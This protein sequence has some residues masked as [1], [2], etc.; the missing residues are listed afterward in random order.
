[1]ATQLGDTKPTIVRVHGAWADAS[2]P[3]RG[4]PR[5]TQFIVQAAEAATPTMA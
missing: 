1:M 5:S 2:R 3:R 4:D